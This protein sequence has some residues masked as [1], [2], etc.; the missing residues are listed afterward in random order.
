[1]LLV[2]SFFPL[3]AGTDAREFDL[4]FVWNF[5]L[6]NFDVKVVGEKLQVL[7]FGKLKDL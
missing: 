6:K 2:P 5:N 4:G 7:D 1:M 3:I